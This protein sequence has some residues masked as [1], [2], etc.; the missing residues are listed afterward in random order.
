MAVVDRPV[1]EQVVA[2]I[3][4]LLRYGSADGKEAAAGALGNMM[5][6]VNAKNA[7]VAAEEGALHLLVDL[8]DHNR[9]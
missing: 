1:E 6:N 3:I 2:E 4:R 9:T 5:S 8:L 7:S